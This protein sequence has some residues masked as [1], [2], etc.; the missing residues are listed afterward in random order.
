MLNNFDCWN[1]GRWSEAH[2]SDSRWHAAEEQ[3]AH[4][5]ILIECA[6]VAQA[7]DESSC[8]P[9]LLITPRGAY[10]PYCS[11]CREDF[12]VEIDDGMTE[13]AVE[14]PCG[15]VFGDICL[16]KGWLGSGMVTC[17]N[18]RRFFD[19]S[20]HAF[21]NEVFDEGT[22]ESSRWIMILKGEV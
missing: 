15:H 12:A 4:L 13:K 20:V 17:P 6:L 9:P 10:D 22:Y 5:E 11:I 21:P 14:T 18:C 2:F 3:L 19:R 1:E 8:R 16:G 7:E